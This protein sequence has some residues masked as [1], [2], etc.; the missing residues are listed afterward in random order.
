MDKSLQG[1][2]VAIL[3]ANGFEEATYVAVQKALQGVCASLTLLS[4]GQSLVNG[5]RDGGWSLNFPADAMLSSAL[6]ADFDVLVVPGGS[7][8]VVQLQKTEHTKRFVNG[9]ITMMKPMLLVNEALELMTFAGHPLDM[10]MREAG[11][12]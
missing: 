11:V 1:C 3:V 9:F 10:D 6:A 7:R 5:W 12:R 8:A 4:S 2:K